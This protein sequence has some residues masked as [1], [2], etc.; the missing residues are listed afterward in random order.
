MFREAGPYVADDNGLW[1]RTERGVMQLT[2]CDVEIV[3]ALRRHKDDGDAD[4][5]SYV[6]EVRRAGRSWRCEVGPD[7]LGLSTV[8]RLSGLPDASVLPGRGQDAATAMHVLSASAPVTLAFQHFGWEQVDGTWLYLHGAGAI[9]PTGP[10]GSVVTE[11]PLVGYGLPGPLR[12][13]DLSTAAKASLE[14]LGAEPEAM[15]ALLGAAWRA[16]LPGDVPAVLHVAGEGAELLVRLALGFYGPAVEPLSALSSLQG[17]LDA[18][19]AAADALVAVGPLPSEEA[20]ARRHEGAVALML[21]SVADHAS[22]Y[23]ALPDGTTA[24]RAARSVALSA[25]MVVPGAASASQRARTLLVRASVGGAAFD[26]ARAVASSGLFAGAMA[27]YVEWLAVQVAE[28]GMSAVRSEV[29]STEESL[30]ERLGSAGARARTASAVAALA[31]GWQWWLAFC[32]ATG[33]LA[34]ETS[35]P[36]LEAALGHLRTL[37]VAQGP[38]GEGGDFSHDAGGRPRRP[39]EGTSR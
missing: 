24:S 39:P 1:L 2:N 20:V 32:R 35:Q 29:A 14:A 19:H 3:S 23:R 36:A 11:T 9:G 17:L 37:A 8:L 22:R 28:R 12:G 7:A 30:V 6:V 34:P 15:A 38:W 27:S 4:E 13:A 18:S 21:R 33:A 26:E 31:A 25:G 16:P 10:V 5:V